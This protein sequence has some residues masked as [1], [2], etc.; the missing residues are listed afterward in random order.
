MFRQH[1]KWEIMTVEM[2]YR[3]YEDAVAGWMDEGGRER[4][5][6]L[7]LCKYLQCRQST[8]RQSHYLPQIHNTAT[9]HKLT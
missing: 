3:R 4:T 1:W 7:Q 2:Q 8:A 6:R 9:S 5:W